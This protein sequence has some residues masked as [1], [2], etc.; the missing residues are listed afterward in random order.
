MERIGKTSLEALPQRVDAD[1]LLND[2]DR[3]WYTVYRTLKEIFGNAA[4]AGK[5]P[6]LLLHDV[7]W[8]RSRRDLYYRSDSIPGDLRDLHSFDGGMKIDSARTG[9]PA[10]DSAAMANLRMHFT[11]EV[12]ATVCR[13]QSTG[14]EKSAR[15][16][17]NRR[18]A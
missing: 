7:G 12:R 8:P 18:G 9:R 13:P 2:G 10:E 6:V 5:H 11:S 3:D 16:C 1:S 17:G 4:A 15:R 14:R